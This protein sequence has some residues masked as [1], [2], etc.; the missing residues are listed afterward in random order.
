MQPNSVKT[1]FYEDVFEPLHSN[2][3]VL[4]F[5]LGRARIGSIPDKAVAADKATRPTPDAVVVGALV[6]AFGAPLLGIVPVVR[7]TLLT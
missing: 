7:R 4:R 2:V 6:H 5:F 3:V 1:V